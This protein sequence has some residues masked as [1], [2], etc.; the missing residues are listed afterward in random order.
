MTATAPVAGRTS[1]GQIAITVSDVPRSTAFYRDQVGLPF[2]F[3]AGPTLAFL[4]LGG[5][6]IML[7]GPEGGF[8]PGGGTVLYIKVPDITAAYEMMRARGVHFVDEPHLIARM[9]DH[10]LWITSFRDP[11]HHMLALMCER[12]RAAAA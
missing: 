5:V 11:D 9:P 7:T 1:L 12:P 8:T 2:L 10:D 6:R 3:A 4:D